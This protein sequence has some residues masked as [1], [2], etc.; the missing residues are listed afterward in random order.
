MPL[1]IFSYKGIYTLYLLYGCT[2]DIGLIIPKKCGSS[3]RG[4]RRQK[5]KICLINFPKFSESK[6]ILKIRR[7]EV[8]VWGGG[9]KGRTIIL[10]IS[11]ILYVNV[12]VYAH[13]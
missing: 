1:L 2:Y 7:S 12:F 4:L 6:E 8:C 9:A 10:S 5:L 13:N 3:L 11:V